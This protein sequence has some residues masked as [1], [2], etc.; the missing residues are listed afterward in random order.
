[1]PV[2]AVPVLVPGV[3]L[4]EL[5]LPPALEVDGVGEDQAGVVVDEVPLDQLLDLLT[6]LVADPGVDRPHRL[7]R[8]G[9][10]VDLVER[11][12]VELGD[13][14]PEV[15]LE[16][17]ALLPPQGVGRHQ[18]E[19]AVAVALDRLQQPGVLAVLLLDAF[20]CPDQVGHH[21]ACLAPCPHGAHG[22]RHPDAERRQK[23]VLARL[24]AGQ[25]VVE[26]GGEIAAS[27]C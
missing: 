20:G 2:G 6:G 11:P 22:E 24:G 26:A 18:L 14:L 16:V 5:L 1:M 19:R 21:P 12:A 15:G 3:G 17:V 25:L 23:Q 9:T 7:V 27:G 10:E 13:G 8:L 4:L